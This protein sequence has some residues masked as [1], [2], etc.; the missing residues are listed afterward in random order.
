ML[1]R[2]DPRVV[3][4]PEKGVL[5][6]LYHSASAEAVVDHDSK[7]GNLLS[8]EIDWED[9]HGLRLYVRWAQEGVL[10][11]GS[12]DTGDCLGSLNY[13]MSPI[14]IRDVRIRPDL[15]EVARRLIENSS[16]EDDLRGAILNQL[17]V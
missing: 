4:Q 16:I 2:V 8:F 10:Q 7:N 13:K 15:V 17:K 1:K 12:I 3:R 11:T 9:T 5:R 6:T 14:L